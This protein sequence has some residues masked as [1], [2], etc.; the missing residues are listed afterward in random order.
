[1]KKAK[2]LKKSI[3]VLV[4]AVMFVFMAIP[5]S[6]ASIHWTFDNGP[7]NWGVNPRIQFGIGDATVTIDESKLYNGKP[8]LKYVGIPAD[9]VTRWFF[10]NS[11]RDADERTDD[12]TI[13]LSVAERGMSY[14][15]R[16]FIEADCNIASINPFEQDFPGS[17]ISYN[18]PDSIGEHAGT[19]I[20][21][22]M[23][24]KW[25]EVGKIITEDYGPEFYCVGLD[26]TPID[27]S[28]PITIWL[29]EAYLG[30]KDGIPAFSP[31][32]SSAAA[33]TPPQTAAPSGS[34]DSIHWT[35]DTEFKHWR[36]EPRVQFGIGDATLG[37]DDNVL[38]GGKPT[39]K[40]VGIPAD[41]VTRYFFDN[42]HRDVDER[43][44]DKTIVLSVAERGMS[45]IARVF[46]DENCNIASINPFEQDFPGS[47]ISYNSPDS[48]GEHA[49]TAI[50]SSMYG[51]W[52]E[53]GKIIT[54]DY[55]PE[56]YCVGL[57]ITPIDESKPI[58]IW[59][60][61]AYLGPKAGIPAFKSE[62]PA[63]P[64]E[65]A[66]AGQAPA[67]QAPAAPSPAAPSAPKVGDTS[68]F[69]TFGLL[70][71]VCAAVSILRVSRKK[72]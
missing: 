72:V 44:D 36:V 37:I 28:K 55:G 63:A 58:T 50:D 1:M 51:K 27:A 43:S 5:V 17:R 39:L 53:V 12:M 71:F 34:G 25:I 13:V 16:V 14:V 62:A 57:D 41:G 23:Y 2:N 61:E 11:H 15:A 60:G 56:F 29:G 66:P 9:G 24:G 20:D 48:I 46:I 64:A 7:S 18:S 42:A 52:I 38:Y 10:D 21:A 65:Q 4:L 49:G 30:P 3:T 47:R 33:A 69:I 45:F 59:L 35:Y 22:G 26:I 19:T 31:E 8:T 32:G 67:E 6:A 40:Y 68:I 70:V 54:E